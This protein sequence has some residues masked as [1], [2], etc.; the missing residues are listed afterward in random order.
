MRL[1][2]EPKIS[3]NSNPRAPLA[4]LVDIIVDEPVSV[5]IDVNC[6]DRSRA[7]HYPFTDAL[8]RQPPI[9]GLYL[10]GLYCQ[11]IAIPPGVI[12]A[13]LKPSGSSQTAGQ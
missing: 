9:V 5:D 3:L 1:L 13:G 10:D 4:A 12:R 7:L 6:G 8:Q 2:S 11:L